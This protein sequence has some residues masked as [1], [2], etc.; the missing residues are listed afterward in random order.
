[1]IVP[2]L[3]VGLIMAVRESLLAKA[4]DQSLSQCLEDC[5]ASKLPPT[6]LCPAEDLVITSS[7]TATR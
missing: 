1:M 5:F 7:T 2:A 6:V 3:R 4:I